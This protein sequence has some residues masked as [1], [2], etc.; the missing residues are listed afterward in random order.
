MAEQHSLVKYEYQ[1]TSFPPFRYY[2][3]CSCGFTCRM[4]TEFASKDQ[5]D[6][7]L[8]S[9]GCKPHFATQEADG[10]KGEDVK[11]WKPVFS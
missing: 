9:K 6:H 1:S 10:V 8:L 5:F 4:G 11:E 2:C 7:H 3:E